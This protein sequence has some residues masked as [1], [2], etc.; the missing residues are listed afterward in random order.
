[1]IAQR[2][3]KDD[4]HED[5]SP[6]R[7]PRR[8]G[9]GVAEPLRA[10][11][12]PYRQLKEIAIGGDG[13]WDYLSVDSAARRLYVS[14]ATKVVVIDIDKNAVV[15]EIA[16]APGV[17]GIAIA[18]ELGRGFVSNGRENTVSIVDLKTLQIVGKVKT[19]ENPDAILYEP[20][21]KEVYAFNGRGKSATVFDAKTG[22]GQGD[23]P[24]AGQARVRRRRRE[25]RP[26]LQQHRGHER[27]RRDRHGDA[28]GR[29]DLA[30]RAG[31]GGVR[32]RHR[33]GDTTGCSSAAAT[34]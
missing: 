24:A 12:G 33:P 21:H 11:D 27:A 23:D 1:M 19:G 8:A 34:S 22:D 2:H 17:H 26:H 25:G 14:H 29:R 30:D 31:R 28:H 3:R 20:V 4:P 6:G 32:P 16:P 18:P 5:A 13:G 10:A 15:G 9:A 7:G